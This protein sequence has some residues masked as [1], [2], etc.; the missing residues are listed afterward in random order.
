MLFKMWLPLLLV[1]QILAAIL[2]QSPTKEFETNSVA[3]EGSQSLSPKA[4]SMKEPQIHQASST[5]EPDR[6]AICL[7]TMAQ[8]QGLFTL[9]CSHTFH[10]A[11]VNPWL[12]A[13]STCPNC[14]TTH[15]RVGLAKPNL[16]SATAFEHPSRI[17]PR[18]HFFKAVFS[19]VLE[20]LLMLVLP[21][22][23]LVG[24]WFRCSILFQL[25]VF[26]HCITW[27]P[28]GKQAPACGLM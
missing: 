12:E 19:V 8:D 23:F 22:G 15:R 24:A 28:T 21:E 7:G 10:E 26:Y 5:S 2:V 1:G 6:C 11:C 3:L 16:Q 18:P 17:E 20:K 27:V 9:E 25:P 13:K 4:Y 14:R